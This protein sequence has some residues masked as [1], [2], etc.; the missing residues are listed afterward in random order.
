MICIDA[1]MPFKW[2]LMHVIF[3]LVHMGSTDDGKYL[4]LKVLSAISDRG[5]LCWCPVEL[6]ACQRVVAWAQAQVMMHNA[7]MV[8]TGCLQ[9]ASNNSSQELSPYQQG[10][11]FAP[12]I[13]EASVA[14]VSDGI[15]V[16]SRSSRKI[17]EV[18]SMRPIHGNR[19]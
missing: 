10:C 4:G 15:D 11:Y 2:V 13:A 19:S 8:V 1:T 17:S 5:Y 18:T 3:C 16:G 14:V 7:R 6:N 12:R 9:L